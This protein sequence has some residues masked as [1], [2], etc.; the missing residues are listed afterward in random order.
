MNETFK[1]AIDGYS[2]T[3]KSTL[4]KQMAKKL[5]FVYLDTGAMY[6]GITYY[7]LKNDYIIGNRI[8]KKKL[9]QQLNQIHFDFNYNGQ[10][11]N[12]DIFL[13]G[14]NIE[15]YIRSIEVSNLVGSIASI[16]QIREAMVRQQLQIAKGKNI[17]LDGRD[18]GTAVFPNA[19]L[20][21]FIVAS[22]EIRAR[23]RYKELRQKGENVTYK[24]V[25][26]NL[27]QRDKLDT[28]REESPLVKAKDA[29]TIDNSNLTMEA[30]IDKAI[31]LY[32][33]IK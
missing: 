24:K 22:E 1:I 32:N 21:L 30:F 33:N 11:Q 4:A 28:T 6:R 15:S 12:A 14:E 10:I 26:E 3:G 20:K 23:R 2:G 29:I 31:E 5:N 17:I 7:A 18:I 16:K 8:L 13:N 25:F 9:V 19:N 27:K